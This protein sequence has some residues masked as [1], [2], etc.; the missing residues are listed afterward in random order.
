MLSTTS[1]VEAEPLLKS[2]NDAMEEGRMLSLSGFSLF[3]LILSL[4]DS[5]GLSTWPSYR[6]LVSSFFSASL[7]RT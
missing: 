3:P 1:A 4:R 2:R 6:R 7:S 5:A